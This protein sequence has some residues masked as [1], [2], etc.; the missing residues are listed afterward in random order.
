MAV[1]IGD[2]W[3]QASGSSALGAEVAN[4]GFT[5]EIR[6]FSSL[7]T[8]SGILHDATLGASGVIRF[9]LAN[10]LSHGGT[11]AG[12]PSSFELSADGGKTFPLRLGAYKQGNSAL[13]P[14]ASISTSGPHDLHIESSGIL[15]AIGRNSV[16]IQND[17][18]DA[19]VQV[20]SF[21]DSEIS[22]AKH[23]YLS[24]NQGVTV[25]SSDA[26]ATGDIDIKT[27]GDGAD[28]NINTLG[29]ASAIDIR[30]FG[31]GSEAF[32]RTSNADLTIDCG[33]LTSVL[34]IFCDNVMDI[35]VEGAMNIDCSD[36]LQIISEELFINTQVNGI[37]IIS[38]GNFIVSATDDASLSSAKQTTLSAFNSSGQLEYR[39]GPFESWHQANRGNGIFFPIPHS[40]QINHMIQASRQ[41]MEA[42]GS[43][44]QRQYEFNPVMVLTSAQEDLSIIANTA[45]PEFSTFGTQAEI[46]ISGLFMPPTLANLETGDLYM[47]NHSVI[48]GIVPATTSAIAK[49]QALGH[50]TLAIQTGSGVINVSVGSGIAQFTCSANQTLTTSLA[51][52]TTLDTVAEVADQNYSINAG[53][54]RVYSPGLYKVDFTV[55]FTKTLGS[56]V[57]MAQASL[58]VNG[59]SVAGTI[60]SCQ[61]TNTTTA[62]TASNSKAVLVNLNAGDTLSLQGNMANIASNTIRVDRFN[63][64]FIVEKIGP[65]RGA[66]GSS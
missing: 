4:G 49:A 19:V 25:E 14:C 50:G 13:A 61:V 47:M 1:E 36:L 10:D 15:R 35:D 3:P 34:E 21:G 52:I 65:K 40:G 24:G 60:V 59:V 23:L 45:K 54:I 27:T 9:N 64:T 62:A 46:N 48:S 32:L 20:I 7:H 2:I 30:T 39:F 28:I 31:A 57:Q 51:T 41:N 33:G 63:T 8:N 16:A 18:P 66:A 38:N 56:T 29:L 11:P 17:H 55:S 37:T 43:G 6:P 5:G 12:T 42:F 26:T 44:L 22:A 53:F 58:F